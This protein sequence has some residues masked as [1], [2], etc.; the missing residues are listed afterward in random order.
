MIP[1]PYPPRLLVEISDKMD[2]QVYHFFYRKPRV[3][4]DQEFRPQG[5]TKLWCEKTL[6]SFFNF[7][8]FWFLTR[9]KDFKV[10]CRNICDRLAVM[11]QSLLP[12]MHSHRL[13][14]Y[15]LSVSPSSRTTTY[16]H[17]KYHTQIM[18]LKRNKTFF[19]CSPSHPHP[20]DISFI[21]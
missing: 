18:F 12:H 15:T 10:P 1:S 3:E 4:F 16:H 13:L 9:G 5:S 17:T 19:S 6:F 7:S 2:T 20:P 8:C 11:F 21:V 14:T